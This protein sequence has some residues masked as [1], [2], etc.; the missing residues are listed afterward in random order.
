MWFVI[1]VK[2][3][4][5]TQAVS[6]LKSTSKSDAL[7]EVF[8]PMVEYTRRDHG[9]LCVAAEP[10]F[11][12]KVFAVAPSKWELRACMQKAPELEVLYST[13]PSFEPLEPGGIDFINAWA[14]A[15]GR[16][17]AQSEAEVDKAGA[18]TITA[19]PLLGHEDEITKFSSGRRWAYLETQIAG[20]PTRAHVG[21]RVTKNES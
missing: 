4:T 20:Q 19:G 1:H 16:V 3:G 8:C 7:Q 13:S 17:C 5:E 21:V 18:M 9:K 12:G 14:A 10:M 2:P 6:L 11:E 15:P